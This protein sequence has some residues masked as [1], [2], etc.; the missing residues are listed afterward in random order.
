M[1]F[2]WPF[3]K[4]AKWSWGIFNESFGKAVNFWHPFNLFLIFAC[5]HGSTFLNLVFFLAVEIMK[6]LVLYKKY[7]N[8]LTKTF[9]KKHT[10]KH[11]YAFKNIIITQQNNDRAQNQPSRYATSVNIFLKSI[12]WLMNWTIDIF[13]IR[14]IAKASLVILLSFNFLQHFVF[15][16]LCFVLGFNSFQVKDPA[17]IHWVSISIS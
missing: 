17:K 3:L 14:R 4:S 15:C 7:M 6:S 9:G 1:I 12:W 5:R 10:W 2:K 13:L 11:F 8:K 16:V